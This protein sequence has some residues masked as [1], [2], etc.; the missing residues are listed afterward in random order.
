MQIKSS[1][2]THS[3]HGGTPDKSGSNHLGGTNTDRDSFAI[4]P[5]GFWGSCRLLIFLRWRLWPA[6]Y[7]FFSTKFLDEKSEMHYNKENWFLRKVSLIVIWMCRPL[8]RIPLLGATM[9]RE[10]GER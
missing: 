6:S 8:V 4:R 7:G 3:E 9:G 5:E 2:V 10:R 1:S